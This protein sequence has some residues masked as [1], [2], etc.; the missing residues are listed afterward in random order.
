MGIN[1]PLN[2]LTNPLPNN[3]HLLNTS[4]SF[5]QNKGEYIRCSD[6]WAQVGNQLVGNGSCRMIATYK[7]VAIND[8]IY[9]DGTD[10]KVFDLTGGGSPTFIAQLSSG[11]AA[12]T[13]RVSWVRFKNRFLL[14]LLKDS[15]PTSYGGLWWYDAE[16]RVAKKAGIGAPTGAATVAAGAAGVPNGTYKCYVSFVNS[17]GHESNLSPVAQAVVVNQKIAWT[18]IP[19]GTGTYPYAATKRRLYRSTAGQ[20]IGLFLTEIGDNVTTVFTDNVADSALGSPNEANYTLPP[21]GIRNL[22]VLG[23]RVYL[24]ADDGVTMYASKTDASTGLPNFEAYPFSLQYSFVGGDDSFKAI[25]PVGQALYAWGGRSGFRTLGDI[26]V[27]NS[28][29]ETLPWNVGFLSPFSW[30]MTPKGLLFIDTQRKLR[31]FDGQGVPEY[32][33]KR[34]E[35]IFDSGPAAYMIDGPSIIYNEKYDV[36]IIS[37]AASG[38]GAGGNILYYDIDT[39][40]GLVESLSLD[41]VHFNP[42]DRKLYAFNTVSDS[43]LWQSPS[44]TYDLRPGSV[45]A[46]PLIQTQSITLSPG[47]DVYFI[48]LILIV[49]AVP[50]VSEVVPILSVGF[51]LND[52]DNFEN[53]YVDISSD[54]IT[55]PT[56]NTPFIPIRRTIEIPI[57]RRG[58]SI[59]FNISAANTAA[60]TNGLE[61]YYLGLRWRSMTQSKMSRAKL[62]E[63][64]ALLTGIPRFQN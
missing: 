12:N 42:A 23:N 62:S 29:T 7:S 48:S 40:E 13:C 22:A 16:N 53:K 19:T 38:G 41:P 64:Q 25:T 35:E 57:Y 60:V 32:R 63:G 45:T 28:V 56:V 43:Q 11:G 3:T 39:D 46:A 58:Q 44:T 26:A 36:A 50:I 8:L 34:L 2:D 59:R 30:C 52:N 1:R 54:Y 17:E 5:L 10:L 31:L 37:Q 6:G 55:I 33:G 49:K 9:V 15:T 61:I 20:T 24:V 18:N 51:A 14:A 4:F 27:G 47:E 21:D